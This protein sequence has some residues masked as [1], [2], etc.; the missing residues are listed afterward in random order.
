MVDK[1]ETGSEEKMVGAFWSWFIENQEKLRSILKGEHDYI[2]LILN[3][4]SKIKRGLAVEFEGTADNILMTISAD[5]ILEN[6]DTVKNL[7]ENAPSIQHWKFIGFR[8]P[9]PKE[10][11]K[12]ITVKV[13]GVQLDPIQLKFLPIVEDDRLYIQIFHEGLTDENENIISY[14]S[15]MLLDNIIGEYDCVTKVAG[16]EFYDLKESEEFIEDLRPL[17]EMGDF[18]EE[19]YAVEK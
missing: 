14:G 7:I 13:S 16:N 10:K 4:L 8:Q 11:I 12:N 17:T 9:V 1:L 5:G 15:L 3:E 18:L 2:D 19:Y 6:F